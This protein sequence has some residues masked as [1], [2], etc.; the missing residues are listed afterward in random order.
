[1]FSSSTAYGGGAVNFDIESLSASDC[2]EGGHTNQTIWVGTNNTTGGYWAEVGYTYG[3]HGSCV[4]EYYWAR[5]NPTYG[6]QDYPLHYIDGIGTTHNFEAQEVYNGEY[7]VYI[8]WTKVGADVGA[9]PW[10]KGVQTGLEYTDPSGSPISTVHFDWHQVRATACCTWYYWPSGSQE[11][12]NSAHIW[13]WTT[14]WIH[15]F[16]R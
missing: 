15:G 8:D 5:N 3:Y 13:I 2:S 14:Q 11:N 10:T 6:Y 7:D 1:M 16:D 4:L 12:D 9:Y